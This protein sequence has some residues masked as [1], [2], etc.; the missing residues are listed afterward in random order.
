MMDTVTEYWQLIPFLS[1]SLNSQVANYFNAILKKK[2]ECNQLPD[3]ARKKQ[4]INIKDNF[5]LVTPR[6][7]TAIEAW[8]KDLAGSK[9][10]MALAK[11]VCVFFMTY[12]WVIFARWV[13][14]VCWENRKSLI[15]HCFMKF[16]F[17]G[18]FSEAQ[19]K[20]VK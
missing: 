1:L 5:W 6:S 2:A 14:M 11:K 16:C 10:L 17:S 18:G 7:K 3:T 15:P 12:G 4:Q 20:W 13:N 9:P 19:S 8:F